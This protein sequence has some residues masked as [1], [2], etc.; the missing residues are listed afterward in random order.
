LNATHI[1]QE[2]RELWASVNVTI[3]A[4]QPPPI[5]NESLLNY[6]QRH[7]LRAAVVTHG[8][9]ALLSESLGGAELLPGKWSEV[10]QTCYLQELLVQDPNLCADLPPLSPQQQQTLKRGGKKQTKDSSVKED[11]RRREERWKYKG[12]RKEKGYWSDRLVIQELYVL[13]SERS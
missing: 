10:V 1:E 3:D 13:A 2:L 6:W 5:P 8:G 9:R 11:Q 12:V 7:D 4:T